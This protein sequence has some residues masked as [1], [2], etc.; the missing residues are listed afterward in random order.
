MTSLDL[1]RTTG[2]RGLTRV[3]WL[4][5]VTRITR[6]FAYGAL[7]VVLILYLTGLGLSASQSGLLLT[8]ILA[9][10]IVVSFYLTTR[11]DRLGRR[12]I[13]VIGAGLMAAAGVVFAVTGSLPLLMIAG[14]LGVISPS[15]S[16]V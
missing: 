4:F 3:A 11:A 1:P 14:T 13:L 15:G 9:G 12:R 2:L 7:S 10:D 16:E 6:Q 5:L 8:L